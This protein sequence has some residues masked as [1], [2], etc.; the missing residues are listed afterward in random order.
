MAAVRSVAQTPEAAT[1]TRYDETSEEQGP[2]AGPSRPGLLT[3][4]GT[5]APA[6]FDLVLGPADVAPGRPFCDPAE[7]DAD[8][9]VMSGML[10][11]ERAMA[12]TWDH[13]SLAGPGTGELIVA[14]HRQLL[15]VPDAAAL[16]AAHDV[17]AVGFFG[18]LREDVDHSILFDLE[19]RVTETFPVFAELGLL[20]YYDLGPE[21]GRY[22]NLILFWTPDVPDQWHANTAHQTAV[23][24]SPLHYDSIRLHKAVIPGPFLGEGALRIERTKYLDFSRTPPWRSLRVYRTSGPVGNG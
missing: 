12:R 15:A 17:T 8:A 14:G 4:A 11:R 20:S 3:P 10:R 9:L 7:T 22:G 23:A 5:G 19:R 2:G 6:G 16:L 21:H 24:T 13:D 18:Q 1:S